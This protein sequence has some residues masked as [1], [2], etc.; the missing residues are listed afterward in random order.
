MTVRR[1]LVG[2]VGFSLQL[3]VFSAGCSSQET[4]PAKPALPERVVAPGSIE[5]AISI[6][7]LRTTNS[8]IEGSLVNN[9][10]L[11]VKDVHLLVNHSFLWKNERNPGRNNPSR[12]EYYKVLKPIP[13]GA[14][15]AFEHHLDPPLP[16]RNDG[17]F[18]TSVE[19]TSFAEVGTRPQEEE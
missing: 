19:V 13:P 3:S 2:L 1:L 18:V 10:D 15:M 16:K 12:T 6:V 11:E 8:L 5:D 7:D 14:T 4:G 17:R 9:S